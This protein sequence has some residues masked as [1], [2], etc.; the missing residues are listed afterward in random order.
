MNRGTSV[1]K[2]LSTFCIQ[3]NVSD[4]IILHEHRGEPDGM[5]ITHFPLG[6]TLYVGLKNV[7]LRHDLK[8]EKLDAISL[9]APHLIFH[10]FSTTL[11]ERV[12]NILK[13]LFPVP[14]HDSKKC[15]TFANN[16]DLISIRHHLHEKKDYKTVDLVELGPRFEIK[17]Y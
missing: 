4:L 16:S 15:I 8:G 5:I 7:V 12:S 13:H 2:E 1:M 14:K 11:G 3:R 10:N 9:Q 17:P 6:P